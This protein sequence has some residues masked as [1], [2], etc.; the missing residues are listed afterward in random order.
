MFVRCPAIITPW[1]GTM[2]W[3]GKS[4]WA[5]AVRGLASTGLLR[6][7]KQTFKRMKAER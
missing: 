4:K 2:R 3:T 5:V 1:P 6:G 7:S